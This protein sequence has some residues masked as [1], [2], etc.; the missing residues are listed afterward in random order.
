M[1]SQSSI[2]VSLLFHSTSSAASVVSQVS[3]GSVWCAGGGSCCDEEGRG[4]RGSEEPGRCTEVHGCSAQMSDTWPP[5]SAA[6]P[7]SLGLRSPS[8]GSHSPGNTQT[9]CVSTEMSFTSYISQIGVF[10][11]KKLV[12]S[13]IF[14]YFL[15][16]FIHNKVYF[17]FTFGHFLKH[18]RFV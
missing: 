18:N 15:Y 17:T 10:S 4:C 11:V 6:S 2:E 12:C 14:R 8:P 5:L 13:Q 1:S 3:A 7:P 16:V 9:G